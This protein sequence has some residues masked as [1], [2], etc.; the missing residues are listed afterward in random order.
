MVKAHPI[1]KPTLMPT[2][3]MGRAFPIPFFA[4]TK[5]RINFSF[6]S[7]QEGCPQDGEFISFENFVIN[8]TLNSFLAKQTEN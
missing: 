4:T 8:R 1:F 5:K 2:K 6:P 7:F 3:K